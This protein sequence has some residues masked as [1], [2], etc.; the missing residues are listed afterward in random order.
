MEEQ[1]RPAE[2]YLEL[3]L[4][5]VQL[6]LVHLKAVVLS[7]EVPSQLNLQQEVYLLRQLSLLSLKHQHPVGVVFSEAKGLK[8]LRAPSLKNHLLF[9]PEAHP[10]SQ[11][12]DQHSLEELLNLKHCRLR[13]AVVVY[14]LVA[15]LLPEKP[16][17]PQQQVVDCL[18]PQSQIV[19]RRA[20]LGL[21]E[22]I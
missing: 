8:Q 2:V 22:R 3:S 11:L 9:L 6:N 17:R 13:L 1:A 12:V 7:L 20:L 10:K 4:Q 16:K 15:K 21:R 5:E 14:F 19:N 18:Q